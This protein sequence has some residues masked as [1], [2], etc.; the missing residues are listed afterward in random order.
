MQE[1]SE[2]RRSLSDCSS[3]SSCSEDEDDQ[4]FDLDESCINADQGNSRTHP[5]C[6]GVQYAV[7]VAEQR[8][9][10]AYPEREMGQKRSVVNARRNRRRRNFYISALKERLEHVRAYTRQLEASHTQL[11]VREQELSKEVRLLRRQVLQRIYSG[12]SKPDHSQ[13]Q[14]SLDKL[15][16]CLPQLAGLESKVED[17]V[18]SS[19][20]SRCGGPITQV[21]P[22][23]LLHDHSY[24]ASVGTAVRSSE[25][26]KPSRPTN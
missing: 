26:S 6:P 12:L 5:A 7:Q 11:L 23:Q 20:C 25:G 4:S 3:C 8:L 15:E 13:A 9:R 21:F 19:K 14:R 1:L 24:C 22:A 16:D 2:M 17:E 10:D 18:G